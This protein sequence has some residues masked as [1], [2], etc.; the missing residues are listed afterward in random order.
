MKMA[1]RYVVD[2]AALGSLTTGKL[3]PYL[4]HWKRQPYKGH[5]TLEYDTETEKLIK[6]YEV[7][8]GDFY[9]YF[10]VV[11][12]A[13]VSRADFLGT[14]D[15]GHQGNRWTPTAHLHFVITP[16]GLLTKDDDL[17]VWGLLEQYGA[18]L[19]QVRMPTLCDHPDDYIDRMAHNLLWLK[20][21]RPWNHQGDPVPEQMRIPDL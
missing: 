1:P 16:R 6:G 15:R 9:N 3:A 21:H 20:P 7:T 5:A 2:A 10:L 4:Y 12:E 17:G 13:K 11:F 14:F 19:Q 18:G 8:G